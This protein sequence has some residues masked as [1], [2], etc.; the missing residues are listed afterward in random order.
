MLFCAEIAAEVEQRREIS[1]NSTRRSTPVAL[2]L[3]YQPLISCSTGRVVG[4]EAL[5]R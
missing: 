5:L 1:S 4:L 2:Q 3:H